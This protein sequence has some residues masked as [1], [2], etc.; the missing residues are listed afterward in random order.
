MKRTI[1]VNDTLEER[2]ESAISDVQTELENY[3]DANEPSKMPDWGDLDYSGALHEIIDVAVPIYTHEIKTAWFLCGSELEAAYDD[4]GVGE[5]PM[6]NNGMAAIY[7][8]I[9][10]KAQEWWRNNA[11]EIFEKWEARR[12]FRSELESELGDDWLSQWE[13]FQPDANKRKELEETADASEVAGQI[14]GS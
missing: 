4:A 3:L 11:E 9:D 14:K 5:N 10:Q 7:Y 13:R 6:E 2:V 8:Y 1:E 12:D